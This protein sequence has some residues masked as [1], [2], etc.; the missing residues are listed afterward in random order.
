MKEIFIIVSGRNGEAHV[1]NGIDELEEWRTDG[2]IESGDEIYKAEL[3][4]VAR[5]KQEIILEEATNE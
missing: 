2:S 3:I 5:R 1:I 4:R